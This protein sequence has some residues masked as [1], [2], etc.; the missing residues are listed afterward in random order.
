MPHCS[1]ASA[2]QLRHF[3]VAESL[4]QQQR[5]I[6]LR[7]RQIPAIELLVDRAAEAVHQ[8]LH[9]RSPCRA[10]LSRQRELAKHLLLGPL[11]ILDAGK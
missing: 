8:I 4:E 3:L 10:L 5:Y 1:L 2:A 7:R 11:L 9:A 6:L